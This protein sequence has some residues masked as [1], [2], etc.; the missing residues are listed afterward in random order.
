MIDDLFQLAC[1]DAG[2]AALEPVV[3]DLGA[4]VAQCAARFE[5]EARAARCTL[6]TQVRTGEPFA[7]C[8]PEQ[9]ERVLANLASNSLRHTPAG[10]SVTFVVDRTQDEVR[11]AVQDTGSGIPDALAVRVFEPFF[12]TD[13]ARTPSAGNV[14]LGLAI[15]R[16]LIE[17]QGGR[18]WVE[19]PAPGGARVSFAL[20]A[21][22]GPAPHAA[23]VV[24]GGVGTR[25]GRFG[26]E[27]RG[28]PEPAASSTD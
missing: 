1:I 10:G 21:A 13:E 16:G 2:A 24:S 19:T 22:A 4:L 12:R 5:V 27:R 7:R 8:V 25:E 20:P 28:E 9:V 11:V 14:G 3:S 6:V 18:I 26:G 15:A 17:S 23:T